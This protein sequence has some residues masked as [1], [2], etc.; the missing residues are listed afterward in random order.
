MKESEFKIR[1]GRAV[2]YSYV[3]V[4]LPV[5]ILKRVDGEVEFESEYNEVNRDY[6]EDEFIGTEMEGLGYDPFVGWFMVDEVVRVEGRK[7]YL[8]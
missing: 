1:S 6:W 8:T 2:L 4:P 7:I 3:G 5:T